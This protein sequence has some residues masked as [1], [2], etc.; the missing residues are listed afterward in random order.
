MLTQP[1]EPVLNNG[2][3]NSEANLICRVHDVLTP[4]KSKSG[5]PRSYAVLDLLGQGTFGQVRRHPYLYLGRAFLEPQ[6]KAS[7][8]PSLM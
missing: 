4:E 5:L 2:A 8:T 3:D 7:C 6:P 1:A